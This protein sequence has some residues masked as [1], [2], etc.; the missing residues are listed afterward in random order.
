MK[1]LEIG[2]NFKKGENWDLYNVEPRRGGLVHDMTDLPMPN[3][4]DNT[5]DGVFS[6]HFIEHITKEDGINFFKEM[7]RVMKPGAVIRTIWPSMDFV[8]HLNSNEDM[9]QDKFVMKY[10][11]YFI[12][13]GRPKPFESSYYDSTISKEELEKMTKQQQ[14]AFRICHQEG[15]HKHIWYVQEMINALTEI[16]FANASERPYRKSTLDEFN[17]I[18]RNDDIRPPHSGVVEAIKL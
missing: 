6:E 8:D 7:H 11:N 5:Y 4:E 1:F 13:H 3:V 15:E 9:S 10:H 2:G 18:D 16:G 17:N 14:V 12:E